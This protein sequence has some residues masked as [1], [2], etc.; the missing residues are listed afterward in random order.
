MNEYQL[1]KCLQVI[2][3]ACIPLNDLPDEHPALARRPVA[4][5]VLTL[6]EQ[7]GG[8][9]WH[10]A[11]S[12]RNKRYRAIPNPMGDARRPR[13]A[14]RFWSRAD[15]GAMRTGKCC[16]SL[17]EA[18]MQRAHSPSEVDGHPQAI[19]CPKFAAWSTERSRDAGWPRVRLPVL[20][21]APRRHAVPGWGTPS[22]GPSP[23]ELHRSGGGAAAPIPKY[24][25]PEV[26]REANHA[27][28]FELTVI[29]I[30]SS[31][32]DLVM[33]LATPFIMSR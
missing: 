17:E 7:G 16:C 22:G 24:Q 25:P 30:S 6:V 8:Q 28:P 29:A 10:L 15:H 19:G 20:V 32:S 11:G 13:S 31:G 12:P 26:R 1:P 33:R 21:E 14:R 5:A 3:L 2:G 9:P 18:R 27:L 4:A 23:S